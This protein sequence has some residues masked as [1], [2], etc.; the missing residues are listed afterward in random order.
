MVGSLMVLRDGAG[1]RSLR[2]TTRTSLVAAL[3]ALISPAPA[4]G[5]V[6]GNDA[7]PHLF[8]PQYLALPNARRFATLPH[9]RVA[10]RPA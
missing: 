3:A 4:E 6:A 9:Q 1:P 8:S 2:Y 7:G 5:V 10:Q